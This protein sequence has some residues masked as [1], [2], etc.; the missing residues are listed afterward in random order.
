MGGVENGSWLYISMALNFG[1]PG[2]MERPH[3]LVQWV[4]QG[5]LSKNS[6]VTLAG[7]VVFLKFSI[8][9]GDI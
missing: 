7:S 3:F 1:G 4:P 9:L 8:S 6:S 2:E 5:H